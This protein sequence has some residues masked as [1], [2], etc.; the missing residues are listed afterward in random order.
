MRGDCRDG[1]ALDRDGHHV[2]A[3]QVSVWVSKL[4]NSEVGRHSNILI[5]NLVSMNSRA[6]GLNVHGATRGITLQNSHI[7]NSGDDCIGVWSTGLED[8]RI[9]IITAKN[10]AVMAGAHDNWGSCMGTYAFQSLSVER[11][12]CFDPFLDTAGCNPR[13]H[14][15]ALHI[16]SGFSKDCMPPGA[17]LSLSGIEYTASARPESPLDRPRCGNCA[18]C[19]DC[20]EAGYRNLVHYMDG[21][22]ADG[23]CKRENAGC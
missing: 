22:V 1:E 6:D 16:N 20:S 14:Y 11:L 12:A 18:S 4:P 13:T 5:D 10:C 9:I 7:E 15:T 3:H 2:R 23:A 8:M 21:S 17:S 19:C